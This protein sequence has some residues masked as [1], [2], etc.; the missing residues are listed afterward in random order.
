M[1]RSK[2]KKRGATKGNWLAGIRPAEPGMLAGPIQ[3]G[4]F[5]QFVSTMLA[6][7]L[8]MLSSDGHLHTVVY[9]IDAQWRLLVIADGALDVPPQWEAHEGYNFISVPGSVMDNKPLVRQV[10]ERMSIQG[11]VLTGE[12]WVDDSEGRVAGGSGVMS[13][14]ESLGRSEAVLMEACCPTVGYSRFALAPMVRMDDSVT[15]SVLLD[16]RRSSGDPSEGFF[17]DCLP[18]GSI[19]GSTWLSGTRVR[20]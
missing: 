6:R 18:R 13:R 2:R 12:A 7:A 11:Y 20:D 4:G 14:T 10:F 9:A 17:R 15:A 8:N 19:S 5:D 3:E 16:I 1:G